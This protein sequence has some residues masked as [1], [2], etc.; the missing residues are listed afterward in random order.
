MAYTQPCF[1]FLKSLFVDR[2]ELIKGD[3]KITLPADAMQMVGRGLR[4]EKN[5]GTSQ[6]RIVT[7]VDNLGRFENKHPYHY[8]E[9]YFSEVNEM[10]PRC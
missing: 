2:I 4:G 9:R 3:S 10:N 1:D 8:C 6:C 7:V 5:G